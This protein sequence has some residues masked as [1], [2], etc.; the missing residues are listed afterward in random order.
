MLR[1][2]T[3][4]LI[5][6][7]SLL[8]AGSASSVA[9]APKSGG[10]F[11][12][13]STATVHPGVQTYTGPDGENQCTS[14]FLFR[15]GRDL[16]LG[17]AAHCAGLGAANEVDGCLAESMPLGTPVEI[18]G[19][20]RPGTLVYSSWL[21]MQATGEQDEDTCLFND[22]ALVRLDR[23]DHRAVNPSVPFFGGPVALASDVDEG[24]SVFSYGNS[25]L[26]L[27]LSAL[28]PKEGVKVFTNGDGWNHVVYTVTPG[29]PGDSGSGFLDDEGRAFGVLSTLNLLPEPAGNGVADL[30]LALQYLRTHSGFSTVALVPGTEPFAGGVIF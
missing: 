12:P 4:V 28:S 17:Q 29:V 1:R 25:S 16:F 3:V 2:T 27:G 26:R 14:N 7:V 18:E 30:A 6:L 10:S 20:S 8:A 24:E 5:A 21:T 11:A 15:Q 22:F 9:S 23:A 19:A 13:A